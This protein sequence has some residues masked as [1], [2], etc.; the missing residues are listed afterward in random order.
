MIEDVVR[1]PTGT[2]GLAAGTKR[3]LDETTRN[4]RAHAGGNGRGDLAG[5]VIAAPVVDL[6]DDSDDEEEEEE[7][8][9]NADAE[10]SND[11]DEAILI[12]SEVASK[13][14]RT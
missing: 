13:R 6:L 14:P 2:S 5:T 7:S 10:G 9:A 11:G 12:T 4:S 1:P 3:V 8:S